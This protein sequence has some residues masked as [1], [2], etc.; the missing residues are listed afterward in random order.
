MRKSV[1]V[2]LGARGWV[3][4]EWMRERC[5]DY[6]ACARATLYLDGLS[7]GRVWG[8]W[9]LLQLCSVIP[10]VRMRVGGVDWKGGTEGMRSL[11]LT[12]AAFI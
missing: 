12:R 4:R 2:T 8:L 5:Q 10:E 3:G 6:T 9:A 7:L 1:I 11:L